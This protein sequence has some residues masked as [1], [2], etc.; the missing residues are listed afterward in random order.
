PAG[1]Y[2]GW[3]DERCR[4]A[5]AHDTFAARWQLESARGGDSWKKIHRPREL[6]A[7]ELF[8]LKC[9]HEVPGHARAAIPDPCVEPVVA[10]GNRR[11][12]RAAAIVVVPDPEIR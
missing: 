5:C 12:V 7:R 10:S 9:H 4:P 1:V 6:H 2:P 8:H 11:L 3:W